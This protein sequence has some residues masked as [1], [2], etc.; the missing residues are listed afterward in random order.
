MFFFFSR[1]RACPQISQ[2]EIQRLLTSGISTL[3]ARVTDADDDAFANKY[4]EA[5]S[6]LYSAL[7]PC[8]NALFIPLR[9]R[10]GKVKVDVAALALVAFRDCVVGPSWRRFECEL[11]SSIIPREVRFSLLV[12]ADDP[13]LPLPLAYLAG[14]PDAATSGRFLQMFLIL[15]MV[16]PAD[17]K[18]YKP[19]V[20]ALQ[21]VE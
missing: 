9:Q 11:A 10:Q 3:A 2:A 13:S 8:L 4:A 16:V 21:A 17:K 5:W 18:T 12:K 15:G 14:A 6:F 19:L 20:R 7:I 1:S